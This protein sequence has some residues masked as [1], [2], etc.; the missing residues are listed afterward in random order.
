MLRRMLLLATLCCVAV[1]TPYLSATRFCVCPASN[2]SLSLDPRAAVVGQQKLTFVLTVD[3]SFFTSESASTV[4]LNGSPRHATLSH[5]NELSVTLLPADVNHVYSSQL[6][7]VDQFGR[8]LNY[9]FWVFQPCGVATGVAVNSI[10]MSVAADSNDILTGTRYSCATPSA[11]GL[12]YQCVELIRRYYDGLVA[13]QYSPKDVTQGSSPWAHRD[14]KDF[15]YG[16]E[17]GLGLI[18]FSNGDTSATASPPR[19]DD[20]LVFQKV[21]S[22][23]GRV[24][25]GDTG[26]VAIVTD[27][28]G[29]RITILEQNWGVR[30]AGD[31][32]YSPAMN[33]IADRQG[34][35]VYRVL[36]WLRSANNTGTPA[37]YISPASG[38]PGTPFAYTGQGFT[39]NSTA[40][41]H[42]KR[43]D[44]TEFASLSIP[45]ASDGTFSTSINSTGFSSG[46]YE[47]WAVDITTT[48]SSP[49]V[50]FGIVAVN[51]PPVAG[52]TMTSGSQSV[53]DG[54]TLNAT[55]PWNVGAQV[56]LSAAGRSVDPEGGALQYKWTIDGFTQQD[57]GGTFNYAFGVGTHAV[58]LTVTDNQNASSATVQGTVAVTQSTAPQTFSITQATDTPA[59]ASQVVIGI[60][61][62]GSR[63]L[64][65]KGCVN[66]DG[67][68]QI[69]S[70]N[71]DGSSPVRLTPT[72]FDVIDGRLGGGKVA[73]AACP[74]ATQGAGC[75]G[76]I[77]VYV[78]DIDDLAVTP[79]TTGGANVDTGGRIEISGNGTKVVYGVFTPNYGVTWYIHN[80]TDGTQQE[81]PLPG[82]PSN[83][84]YSALN[85]DGSRLAV[86]WFA[87]AT[88]H[89]GVLD[90]GAPNPTELLN[91]GS[92]YPGDVAISGDGKRLLFS[93]PDQTQPLS[94]SVLLLL[95]VDGSTP[96]KTL[97]ATSLDSPIALGGLSTDYSG[98]I[99]CYLRGAQNLYCVEPDQGGPQNITN[100]T[101]SG[102]QFLQPIFVSGNGSSVTFVVNA[103][104]DP[105]Q[106]ADLSYEVFAATLRPSLAVDGAPISTH[107]QSETFTFT[108]FGFTH[109]GPATRRV[110]H[111]SVDVTLSPPMNADATGHLLPWT[112]PSTC[113]TPPG[114][115]L[116]W[117][118]DEATGQI[119]NTV[120][121]TVAANPSCP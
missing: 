29:T 4:T 94:Y 59:G 112:F 105:G 49:H 23:T 103:D 87:Q 28:T 84:D 8:L 7:V 18:K 34:L 2:P 15:W 70:V 109:N 26:H 62:D 30:G 85:W 90:I 44:G 63:V 106:N 31:L 43:P 45:I 116:I 67:G 61:P 33:S 6:S 79:V 50:T 98:S 89:I 80:L 17:S 111:N 71:S 20:I 55:V 81:L 77:N 118:V 68:G 64:Y 53:T 91:T 21:S 99:V 115:Y 107:T 57:V 66:C 54:Q 25:S 100:I 93:G 102:I 14:A 108:G 82:G 97:D 120:T 1:T 10:G 83:T 22:T 5:V 19:K 69:W 52:F 42:L 74:L 41:S 101:S 32:V 24:I 104:L 9:P 110:R 27:L 38:Q 56:M 96:P 76:P 58:T 88:W 86:V 3:G 51:Q 117:V 92:F 39:G 72:T 75:N 119:S 48:A 73:F 121:E 46:T 65:W 16:A 37:V 35:S 12:R 114:N 40:T 47:V 78:V 13:A 11:Y 36:G 95:T 113:G 60:S